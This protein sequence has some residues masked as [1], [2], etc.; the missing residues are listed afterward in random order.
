MGECQSL[1]T[2]LIDFHTHAFPDD[3]APRA[4]ETLLGAYRVTPVTDGSVGALIRHMDKARINRAVLLPVAT[5]P[6]QVQSINNWSAGVS[7]DRIMAFGAIHPGFPDIKGEI[8]RIVELG[9]PGIKIQPNWQGF[10]ADDREAYPIYEAAQGKLIVVFHCGKE[11]AEFNELKA[12]PERIARVR[13]HFPELTIVVAHMGGYRMWDEVEK[14]LLGSSVYFDTSAC[15]PND[16]PDDRFIRLIREHG[17]ERI[18]F[19]TDIPF[20]DPLQDIPRLRGFGFTEDELRGILGGNA[21]RLL[22]ATIGG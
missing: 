9:L 16:L 2:E 15:F 3:L 17:P 20:G 1:K 11:L 6:A 22:D 4:I 12:T 7:C 14:F 19:G 5:K 10:Y 8:D 13:R 18:L 21:R